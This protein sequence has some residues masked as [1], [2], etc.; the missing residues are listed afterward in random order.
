MMLSKFFWSIRQKKTTCLSPKNNQC[1]KC[2]NLEILMSR[3]VSVLVNK[4]KLG[5]FQGL[6]IKVTNED[7][8]VMEGITYRKNLRN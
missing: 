3:G 5:F 1:E 7:G 6:G 8:L 2:L 4:D